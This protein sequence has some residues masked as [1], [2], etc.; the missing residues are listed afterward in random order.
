VATLWERNCTYVADSR[1]IVQAGETALVLAGY[2]T[3]VMRRGSDGAWRY[4]IA[5]LSP[6]NTAEREEQ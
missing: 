2:G 3:N 4:A 6:D 1:R 5:V